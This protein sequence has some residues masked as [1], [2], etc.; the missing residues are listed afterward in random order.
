M[1]K[2]I[3]VIGIINMILNNGHKEHIEAIYINNKSILNYV[4]ILILID[5]NLGNW[6]VHIR[7]FYTFHS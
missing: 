5:W 4:L 2:R 3:L 6:G 1:E 7:H